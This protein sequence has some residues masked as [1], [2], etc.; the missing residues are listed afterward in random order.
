MARNILPF[1]G[2]CAPGYRFSSHPTTAATW[3]CWAPC[4]PGT[5]P[6]HLP[7]QAAAH[8]ASGWQP[9]PA[10]SGSGNVWFHARPMNW[11]VLLWG[12]PPVQRQLRFRRNQG[13]CPSP[14]LALPASTRHKGCRSL[15]PIQKNT[16]NLEPSTKEVVSL[17]AHEY[18]TRYFSSHHGLRGR[19]PD[20]LLTTLLNSYLVLKA[21]VPIHKHLDAEKL[22]YFS[23]ISD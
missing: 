2:W 4:A 1:W 23:A 16:Q 19:H 3:P 11:N 21:A 5:S 6:A 7:E 18:Y 10:P 8:T 20:K 12:S 22:S 15:R 9:Q 13:S 17:T 14:W